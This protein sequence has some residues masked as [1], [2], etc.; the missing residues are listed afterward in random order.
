[1]ILLLFIPVPERILDY[2]VE[3]LRH[4][5]ADVVDYLFSLTGMTY[6]RDSLSFHL[7]NISIYVA[8]EC[9]GIRSSIALF[10]TTLLAGQ[11]MLKTFPGKFIL[12]LFTPFLTILKNG[13]RITT[14][15]ILADKVDTKWLTDSHLHHNGGI[16]FFGIVLLLLFGIITVIQKIEH[17]VL[18]RQSTPS[19]YK[20]N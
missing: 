20:T 8:K 13:I 16:V 10:I 3:F 5:S 11:L 2:A 1:M 18:K 17:R 7:P 14:L 12:I 19:G 15:T 9:S 4:G 6:V